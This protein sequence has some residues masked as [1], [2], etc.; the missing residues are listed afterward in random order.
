MFLCIRLGLIFHFF[1]E[2]G[3]QNQTNIVCLPA[4]IM[5]LTAVLPLSLIRHCS[6]QGLNFGTQ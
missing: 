3:E 4:L 2:L 6:H 1:W 5:P